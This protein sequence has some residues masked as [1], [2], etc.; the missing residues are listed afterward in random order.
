[1][2]LKILLI[3]KAGQVGRELV[4]LLGRAG[5]L[6]A[7]DRHG[8]DLSVPDEIRRVIRTVRP[9][10][11]V[12]AAAYTAVDR[13]ESDEASARSVNAVA[14]GV[15][16]EE[17]KE[18]GALLVHYST[19][20]VFD[21]T[22]GQP[23]EEE[24]PPHPLSVYGRT[25]LEGERAIQQIAPAY[26]ILRTAWVYAREGRNFLLTVLRLATE[27][28]ELRI[29]RDQVGAP[30][31]SREIAAAT[32]DILS[33]LRTGPKGLPAWSEIKDIYHVSAGGETNWFEFARAILDLA[34]SQMRPADWFTAATMN[35]PLIARHVVPIATTE[36]PTPATRPAY[37]VLA[38]RKVNDKFGV[39]LPDWETQLR[40]VF[41]EGVAQGQ[42]SKPI[43]EH[44]R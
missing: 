35:R 2:K 12:N 23:Y 16:A 43:A 32:A 18:L 26:L 6:T 31:W 14:P 8:L 36:Y 42:G 33:Q 29:V 21:G 39:R 28:Q 10:W 3:G 11:I 38:N 25:K 4:P 40:S 27:K 37:S 19:D 34:S 13:A 9:D 5:E 1:V 7:I 44:L 41:S 30:T 22:K 24:D 20:Y 17:A 15:M